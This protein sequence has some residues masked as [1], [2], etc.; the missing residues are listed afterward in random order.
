M[1]KKHTHTHPSPLL[2]NNDDDDDEQT[3]GRE[4]EKKERKKELN[5]M[6]KLHIGE[7]TRRTACKRLLSISLCS[8]IELRSFLFERIR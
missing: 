7:R 8:R 2:D 5:E 6:T 4:T 1:K 3:D